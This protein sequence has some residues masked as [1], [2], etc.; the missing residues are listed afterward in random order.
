MMPQIV[1]N[2]LEE[3]ATVFNRLIKNL[4]NKKSPV[5]N[6]QKNLQLKFNKI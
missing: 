6:L 5:E 4:T 3:Y 1:N 2:L